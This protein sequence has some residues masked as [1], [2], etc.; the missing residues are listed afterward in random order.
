VLRAFGLSDKGRVRPINEDCFAVR[1]DLGLCVVA[2]GMGGHNAGEVA[3][4]LAIDAV[5]DVLRGSEDVEAWP[6]GYDPELS[7][8]GNLLRTAVHVASTQV[9]EAASTDELAGMGTTIVAVRVS[10]GRLT[11]AHAGDS[12]LYILAGGH[13]SQI[14]K[15]DSWLAAMLA[16]DPAADV[17]ALQ[18]HP[19]CHALTNVI[20]ARTPTHVHVAERPLAGGERLLLSTDGVHGVVGDPH[21][22]WMLRAG[23]DPAAI[24]R[25][26]VA[27]ALACGS[28]DNCTA[29]VAE[30]RP[31]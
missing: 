31:A 1:E 24:A 30:Y 9:L 23:A 4:Q 13:L 22:E 18:R 29:V 21:L 3:A 12:R 26:V 28:R 2:D 20:G 6:F 10:G 15:D 27:A 7:D 5:V 17:A 16:G 8:A 14:T 11:V 19:M 25:N